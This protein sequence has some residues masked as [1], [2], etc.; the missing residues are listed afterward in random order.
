MLPTRLLPSHR[1][2]SSIP[3]T[4]RR[5]AGPAKVPLYPRGR[6][7]R[8]L[9]KRGLDLGLALVFL[10]LLGWL[11]LV[12]AALIR[13]T[14]PGGALFRQQRVGYLERDFVMY[15]FRTMYEHSSEDVHR[16]YVTRLIRDAHPEVGGDH[17][18]YKL[19]ADTRLTRIGPFLR[20]TSLDELP[21]LFNVFRGEMSLV[22]P[23]PVLRYEADLLD[24]RHRDRFAVLPGM[25]GLWQTGGRNRLT[26]SEAFDL[27]VAYVQR[28]SLFFD[29]YI[30]LKTVPAV[31]RG[32]DAE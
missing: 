30:L 28:Q 17:R 23:R 11:M 1:R 6:R 7:S 27:D 26:M 13:V 10:L 2:T 3:Q 20:R 22:G 31:L 14:S 19:Q 21:Q 5:A 12:L 24:E 32:A 25:T 8:R 16:E 9:A 15:K 4:A 18:L 29:L